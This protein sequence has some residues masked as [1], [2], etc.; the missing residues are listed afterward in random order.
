MII[1]CLVGRS[2]LVGLQW[3]SRAPCQLGAHHDNIMFGRTVTSFWPILI[4]VRSVQ[5]LRLLKTCIC[6]LMTHE[7]MG[8]YSTYVQGRPTARR[9]LNI[10]L[11]YFAAFE[12][13]H[14]QG[15][16]KRTE[17]CQGRAPFVRRSILYYSECCEVSAIASAFELNVFVSRAFTCACL[18]TTLLDHS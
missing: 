7:S 13:L 6:N 15:S 8:W 16:T 9:F 2:L 11:T 10:C 14:T 3:Y 1:F 5:F 17:Y 12:L 18:H 4:F